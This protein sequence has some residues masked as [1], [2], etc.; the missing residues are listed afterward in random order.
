MKTIKIAAHNK[1]SIIDV[2]FGDYKAMQKAVGG[3]VETVATEQ[4][5]DFFKRPVIMLVDKE[6]RMKE[7]ELNII[8]TVFNGMVP[9]VGDIVLAQP[10][11]MYGEDMEGIG[12][13]EETMIQPEVAASAIKEPTSDQGRSQA[14]EGQQTFF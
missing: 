8:G 4:M 1:I 12:E 7:L 13:P 11:G 14:P 10:A 3:Y 6:G 2:D 9:I 5:Y